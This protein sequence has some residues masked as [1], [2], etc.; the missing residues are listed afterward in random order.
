M[1]DSLNRLRGLRHMLT[2]PQARNPVELNAHI[3]ALQAELEK[4]RP[5]T[6]EAEPEEPEPDVGKAKKKAR[7]KTR[8]HKGGETREGELDL[9]E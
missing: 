3:D 5:A 1:R 4:C 2:H 9:E 6:E 8:E 7:G